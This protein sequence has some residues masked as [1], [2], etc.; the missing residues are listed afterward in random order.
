[1][2]QFVRRYSTFRCRFYFINF[3][4]KKVI[5]FL[6]IYLVFQ[7]K[8][9]PVPRNISSFLFN[10]GTD[11]SCNNSSEAETK[12]SES[13]L[14]ENISPKTHS[15]PTVDEKTEISTYRSVNQSKNCGKVSPETPKRSDSSNIDQEMANLMDNIYG[16]VWRSTPGLFKKKKPDKPQ[17][18]DVIDELL[19]KITNINLSKNEHK[20]IS[21]DSVKS[22]GLHHKNSSNDSV[23]LLSDTSDDS[24][25]H[26]FQNKCKKTERMNENLYENVKNVNKNEP[27]VLKSYNNDIFQIS[28]LKDK[29]SL[30]LENGRLKS[31]YLNDKKEVSLKPSKLDF[32][33]TPKNI[34]SDKENT[35]ISIKKKVSRKKENDTSKINIPT[36]KPLNIKNIEQYNFMAS[37]SGDYN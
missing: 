14:F 18:D 28:D 31:N 15:T 16:E 35:N 11:N 22:N 23:I 27:S 34:L 9:R 37:L 13:K 30:N 26:D 25:D 29:N 6:K 4:S 19:N 10:S 7:T 3:L 17:E 24:N 1:M 12:L 20:D 36:E 8:R 32:S 5:G 21:N 2:Q 33:D